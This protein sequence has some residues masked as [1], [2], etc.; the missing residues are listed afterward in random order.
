VIAASSKFGGILGAGFGVA[1]VFEHFAASALLIAAPMAV[2]ALLLMR[3][4]IET[5][6]RGL[7]DIQDAFAASRNAAP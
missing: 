4:G 7:E 1:G 3:S 2:A 5:R 6:G